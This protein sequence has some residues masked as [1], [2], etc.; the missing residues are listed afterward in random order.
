MRSSG[1]EERA[2]M[3][4]HETGSERRMDHVTLADSK[5]GPEIPVIH[6]AIRDLHCDGAP[7]PCLLTVQEL[8]TLDRKCL[9]Y[10]DIPDLRWNGKTRQ[11]LLIVGALDRWTGN[12]CRLC[13]NVRP[14]AMLVYRLGAT[15][16][17]AEMSSSLQKRPT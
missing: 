1:L 8:E 3:Q 6:T 16:S 7:C 13:R 14:N 17:G 5:S 12:V 10:M 2:E 9:S 15:D 11:C 4:Q